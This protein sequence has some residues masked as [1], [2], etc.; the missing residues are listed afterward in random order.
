LLTIPRVG[1]RNVGLCRKLCSSSPG[2]SERHRPRRSRARA[3]DVSSWS[4]CDQRPAACCK[5]FFFRLRSIPPDPRATPSRCPSPSP[6]SSASSYSSRPGRVAR[7]CGICL[8][9]GRIDADGL[10]L[11]QTLRRRGTAAFRLRPLHA[12]RDRSASVS[13]K[14]S[15]DLGRHPHRRLLRVPPS[16]TRRHR[17][18]CSTHD[19]SC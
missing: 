17:R 7:P 2:S 9:R 13:A 14:W 8:Q 18:Q 3:A 10:A 6:A 15:N 4:C 16:F 11:D 19:R 12:S 1:R 5:R